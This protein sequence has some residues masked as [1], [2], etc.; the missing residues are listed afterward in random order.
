VGYFTLRAV[1]DRFVTATCTHMTLSE[2]SAV[3]RTFDGQKEQFTMHINRDEFMLL[4]RRGSVPRATRAGPDSPSVQRYEPDPRAPRL[5][6]RVSAAVG[7][8]RGRLSGSGSGPERPRSART[9]GYAEQESY[10]E[11]EFTV[12]FGV[13]DEPWL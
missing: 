13:E 4:S 3:E 12:G 5:G 6:A 1:G 7:G 8:I 11:L 10:I 2:C 9:H